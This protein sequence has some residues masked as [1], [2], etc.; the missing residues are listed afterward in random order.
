MTSDD[1][2]TG[3]DELTKLPP[4][5]KSNWSHDTPIAGPSQF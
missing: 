1:V 3:Y 2:G 4:L 5:A